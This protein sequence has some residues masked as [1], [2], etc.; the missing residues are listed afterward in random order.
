MSRTPSPLYPRPWRRGL[1]LFV[2]LLSALVICVRAGQ[3]QVAQAADWRDL[4]ADQQQKDIVIAA[5][6]GAIL[7]RDGTPCPFRGSGRE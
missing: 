3:I 2:W 1:L 6:R 4:A 7:D 5:P